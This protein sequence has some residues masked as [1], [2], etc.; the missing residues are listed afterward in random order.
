MRKAMLVCLGEVPETDQS[1]G[2]SETHPL[3]K[4]QQYL[5][6]K[7]QPVQSFYMALTLQL[8]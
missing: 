6:L 8:N 7:F 5:N 1:T 4:I 2:T 3:I